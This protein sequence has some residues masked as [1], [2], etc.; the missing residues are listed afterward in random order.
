[1]EPNESKSKKHFWFSIYKSIFRLGAGLALWK[2]GDTMI[3][4]AG[5]LLIIAEILGVMEEL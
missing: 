2:T 5:A 4:T 1:M 3:A